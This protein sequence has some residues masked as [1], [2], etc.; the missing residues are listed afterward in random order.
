MV[1]L[2]AESG[3][4]VREIVEDDATVR[5]TTPAVGEDGT[6]VFGASNGRTWCA[7]VRSGRVL[8]THDDDA[9]VSAAPL[10]TRE[11]VY[12]GRMDRRLIALER[13]TGAP[14]WSATLRGRIKS[15]MAVR[16]EHLFVLAE[17]RYLYHFVPEDPDRE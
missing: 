15:G 5:Y 16:E 10:L 13:E 7:D 6:I 1:I 11:H 4:T 14:V 2:Q 9:V 3:E 8:W 12:V 17:P